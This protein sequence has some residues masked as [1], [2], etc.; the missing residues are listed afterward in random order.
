MFAC[1]PSSSSGMHV[2]IVHVNTELKYLKY[3]RIKLNRFDGFINCMFYLAK[4]TP[5]TE[6]QH[7][8]LLQI[9]KL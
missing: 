9:I 2:D 7:R 6:M 4:C 5:H 8:N 3:I 1:P